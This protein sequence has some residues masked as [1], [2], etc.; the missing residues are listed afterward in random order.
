MQPK[1]VESRS[2]SEANMSVDRA[3]VEE[4]SPV[5][6]DN[7]KKTGVQKKQKP[8]RNRPLIESESESSAM[9]D[10]KFI[11]VD[12]TKS[13]KRRDLE[14]RTSDGGTSERRT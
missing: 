5:L 11:D 2:D 8:N 9:P 7:L 3:S 12:P 4:R 14:N 6:D 1:H 13:F 10:P